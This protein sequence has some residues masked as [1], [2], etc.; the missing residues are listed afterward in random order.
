MSL[1]VAFNSAS[2]GLSQAEKKIAVVAA[3][4][5]N[6]DKVGYTRKIYQ[7][8][9][10]F[11]GTASVPVGGSIVQAQANPLLMKQAN[12]SYTAYNYQTTLSTYLSNYSTSFGGTGKD[13]STISSSIDDLNTALRA[14][15]GNPQTVAARAQ[16]VAVAQQMASQLNSL[17]QSIQN[18]RYGANND[19][20][21][22]VKE[23]QAAMDAITALN[24][25]ISSHTSNGDTNTADMEDARNVA[26]Q[27]LSGILGIQYFT[28]DQNQVEVFTKTGQQLIGGSTN[29]TISYDPVGNMNNTITYPGSINGIMVN[30]QD[31]TT[32]LTEGKLGALISLRDTTL[33]GE[34]AKLDVLAANLQST[35]NGALSKGTAS[36][37]PNSIIGTSLVTAGDAF[38]ATGTLR[39]AVTD[40]DGKVQAYQ[41]L[42]LAS[43]AT[44]G[45]LIAGLN[46]IAGVNA[47]IN[48]EGYLTVTSTVSTS[49]ISIN[50]MDS[51]VGTTNAVEYLGFNNLFTNPN[52]SGA[53]GI[54]VNPNLA[55]NSAS[56]ATGVLSASATLAVGDRGITSG[57]TTVVTDLLNKL[58]TTQTFGAAGNFASRTSTLANYASAMI[59]D[60]AIQ[61][62]NAKTNADTASTTYNYLSTSLANET[63]VNVDEETANLTALQSTYQANAQIIST[64]R[65]LFDSLLQAVR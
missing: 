56:L 16:V 21:S 29:A 39:V 5:N 3:N 10:I 41:D 62:K 32:T 55:A 50:A 33:T 60:A 34:Q 52:N 65:Q 46:G 22:T 9:Y 61:A 4:V 18:Q 25:Q 58:G 42:N 40:A 43:Y 30:G 45:D 14:L 64:V 51:A 26:L 27:S 20:A 8:D 59:A 28:N 36:P 31:I 7:S 63:G 24:R 12:S 13:N 57:D 17:S 47:S 37:A 15:E 11:T 35:V 44:M 49:G 19:I 2:L 1:T 48:A 23:M 54:R 53:A 38:S 6:A